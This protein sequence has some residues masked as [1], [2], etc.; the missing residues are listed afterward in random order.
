MRALVSSVL[1]VGLLMMGSTASALNLI[2]QAHSL[3]VPV[4]GHEERCVLAIAK[5][6]QDRMLFHYQIRSGNE[7][8][9]A[10]IRRPDG[11]KLWQAHESEHGPETKIFFEA[12][13]AGEYEF[14]IHNDG[15]SGTEKIVMISV[16]TLSKRKSQKKIDPILKVLSKAHAGMLALNQDQIYLQTR[17]RE[18]R[19]TLESNNTRVMVRGIIELLVMIGMSLGQVV[20]LHRLFKGKQTRAA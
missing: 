19:E 17:E 15:P 5:G 20:L 11:M 6:P 10:W 14:C 12:Q 8:F 4:R 13:T 2:P 1:L 7:D 16:A 18:H 9:Q 3:T